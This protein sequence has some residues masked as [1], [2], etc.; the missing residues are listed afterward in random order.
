[1]QAGGGG[2]PGGLIIESPYSSLRVVPFG[3][4]PS[5]KTHQEKQAH[6]DDLCLGLVFLLHGPHRGQGEHAPHTGVHQLHPLPHTQGRLGVTEREDA[7]GGVREGSRTQWGRG[8]LTQLGHL[9]QVE[10]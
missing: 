5:L 7:R 4:V 6:L 2:T 9:G 3:Y 10:V 1:M 8:H